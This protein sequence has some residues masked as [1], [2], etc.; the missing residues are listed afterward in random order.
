M[1]TSDASVMVLA[2]D[3]EFASRIYS[4]K[5]KVELRRTRPARRVTR[6]FVYETRPVG[7]VTGWFDVRWVKT[8][9]PTKAWSRFG[10]SASLSRA[11]FRSYYRNCRHAVVLRIGRARRFGIPMSLWQSFGLSRPPQSFAYAKRRAPRPTAG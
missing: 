9:S 1:R 4:G 3:P 11:R 7:S 8:F 5:K 10:K 2:I 6:V